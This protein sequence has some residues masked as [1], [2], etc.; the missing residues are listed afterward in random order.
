MAV[1]EIVIIVTLS[2]ALLLRNKVK[3]ARNRVQLSTR[4]LLMDLQI[5]YY[6]LSLILVLILVFVSAALFRI[7]RD[8]VLRILILVESAEHPIHLLFVY[9]LQ[10]LGLQI[11][12]ELVHE[13]LGGIVIRSQTLFLLL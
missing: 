3:L 11:G 9:C 5:L 2:R 1:V 10:S 6:A 8:R 7:R 13:L 12:V 4:V